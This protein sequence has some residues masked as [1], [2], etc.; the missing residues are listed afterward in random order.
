[1]KEGKKEGNISQNDA[2]NTFYFIWY[3]HMVKDHWAREPLPPHDMLSHIVL[4]RS[5][6]MYK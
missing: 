3:E 2:I 4:L 6:A 1:M 5:V